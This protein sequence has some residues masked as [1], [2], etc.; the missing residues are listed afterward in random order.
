MAG[1]TVDVLEAQYDDGIV[2]GPAVKGRGRA[3]SALLKGF[4]AQVREFVG[5]IGWLG[6]KATAAT[7][8]AGFGGFYRPELRALA[9]EAGSTPTSVLLANLAY[10]LSAGATGCSTFAV[11]AG[12][13][14]LHARN[15]DWNF[16][17][18]L[19]QKHTVI[20]KVRGAPE[21]DYALVTWPGFFGG[22]TA[23]APGR[24][25]VSVNFVLHEDHA[26][27]TSF[28]GRA[29]GG[30]W[31]VPWLVRRALDEAKDFKA[32]VK[33]L[34]MAP[35][36]APVLLTVAGTRRGERVVLERTPTDAV[37]RKGECVWVTN[38]YA[39]KELAASSVDV[40]ADSEGRF[41]AL[42]AR[43]EA[44]PSTAAE[45]F[46][47]L[48]DPRLLM[49]DTVQQVAMSAREGTVTVRVPG[50]KPTHVTL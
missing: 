24:F 15:L 22:L 2:W 43:L 26:A 18:R 29:V 45:A 23:V 11:D 6:M 17:R 36:L 33:L 7:I 9:R 47:L 1:E 48:S 41:A 16:P 32:A 3:A 28:L 8:A 31:P 21:G 13:G 19:L 50:G 35:V 27:V 49:G 39:S 40:G 25:S 12:S 44:P 37:P 38:H 34:S 42:E 20:A 10:D 14:V 5:G 4:E 30:S 46:R